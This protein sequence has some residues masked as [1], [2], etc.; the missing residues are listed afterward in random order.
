MHFD[1]L[2]RDRKPETGVLAEPVRRRPF[3]V[4]APENR[5]E[6]FFR[7]NALPL[8]VDRDDGAPVDRLSR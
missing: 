1:D 8:I 3:G 4:E 6:I 5:F 7:D 2:A